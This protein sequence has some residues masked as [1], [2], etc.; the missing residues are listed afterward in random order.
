MKKY[1][2]RKR[3]CCFYLASANYKIGEYKRALSY[4][5]ELLAL[6]PNN[7]QALDL[8]EKIDKKVT[9]GTFI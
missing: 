3:E 1:P 9:N 7:A 2:Y 8:K 4:I 5:N 6:Q